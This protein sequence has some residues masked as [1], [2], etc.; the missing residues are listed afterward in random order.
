MKPTYTYIYYVRPGTPFF[1]A[2]SD[3]SNKPQDDHCDMPHGLLQQHLHVPL[4]MIPEEGPKCRILWLPRKT[5]EN[6]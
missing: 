1:H 4:G 5:I 2:A 3:F 6:P